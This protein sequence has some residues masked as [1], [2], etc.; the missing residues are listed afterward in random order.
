MTIQTVKNAEKQLK[1]LR[2]EYQKI[3]DQYAAKIAEAERLNFGNLV[4][5]HTNERRAHYERA[6][7]FIQSAKERVEAA[8]SH[9]IEENQALEALRKENENLEKNRALQAWTKAGGDLSGFDAAWPGIRLAQLSDKV[10]HD[11]SEVVKSDF[12]AIRGGL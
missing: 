10:L 8:K 7:P 3:D 11:M 6:M 1:R 4:V 12:P 5:Q 9:E 2:D